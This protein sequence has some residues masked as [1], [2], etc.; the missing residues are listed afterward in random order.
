MQA[1]AQQELAQLRA[2]R[3]QYAKEKETLGEQLTDWK[4]QIAR[5]KDII[6]QLEQTVAELQ[7]PDGRRTGLLRCAAEYGRSD[8]AGPK[9]EEALDGKQ[10]PAAARN[11][12]PSSEE[13]A[14]GC[15]I[16][17]AVAAGPNA[18][19]SFGWSK[20]DYD[21]EFAVEEGSQMQ[22]FFGKLSR[23]QRLVWEIQNPPEYSLRVDRQ[24]LGELKKAGRRHE[25]DLLVTAAGPPS[26]REREYRPLLWLRHNPELDA[27]YVEP[28]VLSTSLLMLACQA[29]YGDTA[30]ELISRGADPRH[31]NRENSTALLTACRRRSWDC[32]R[33]LLESR[34]D[35]NETVSG[36][37]LL[38]WAAGLLDVKKE[39]Q[40][41]GPVSQPSSEPLVPLLL[42]FSA[43]PNATDARGQTA[44][45]H[46]AARDKTKVCEALIAA[47]A[48]PTVKD[49]DGK[50][51]V[52]VAIESQHFG[53]SDWLETLM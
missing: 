22:Q 28:S 31:V 38:I 25:V 29:G 40:T 37:S 10:Q 9:S 15:R 39:Q 34:A 53:I 50:T 7:K 52:E 51:A 32:V 18:D 30:R 16:A 12:G 14:L 33:L 17:A 13:L 42:E 24:L 45:M 6:A 2:A 47:R 21:K 3:A 5:K 23:E 48:D 41:A 4:A 1:S 46:A 36:T 44:L 43:E 27:N 19:L 11:L 26:D 35:P 49:S 20:E 8:S